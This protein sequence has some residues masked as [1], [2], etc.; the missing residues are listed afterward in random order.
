MTAGGPIRDLTSARC[1]HEPTRMGRT[2]RRSRTIAPPRPMHQH[3]RRLDRF[4]TRGRTPRRGRRRSRGGGLR[5]DRDRGGPG[6]GRCGRRRSPGLA[7]ATS[8][9]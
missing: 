3:G 9:R 8:G 6:G 5:R 1:A 4:A 2:A 7:P